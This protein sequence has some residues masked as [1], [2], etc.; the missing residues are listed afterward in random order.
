MFLIL[1]GHR[2][3]Q[4]RHKHDLPKW[5]QK[6]VQVCGFVALVLLPVL[7]LFFLCLWLFANSP[8]FGVLF[9]YFHFTFL[10][11]SRFSKSLAR[12]REA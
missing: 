4:D 12:R 9:V 11:S 5:L 3:A 6:H 8:A 1:L 7:V 2:F 10:F